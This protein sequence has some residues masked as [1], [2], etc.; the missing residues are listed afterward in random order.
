MCELVSVI[1]P[2]YNAENYIGEAIQ[3]VLSQTYDYWELIVVDDGSRDRTPEIVRHW[4]SLDPRIK[5]FA[6]PNGGP[7]KARNLG[8]QHARGNL[9]AFLDADDLWLPTRLEAQVGI[10]TVTGADLVF[11]DGYMFIGNDWSDETQSFG[12]IT[13]RFEGREMLPLLFESNRIPMLSVL[14]RRTV[15]QEACPFL[16]DRYCED[17][18]LWLRLAR[19]GVVF[20]GMADKLVRYRRHPAS[21]TAPHS[22]KSN[23]RSLSATNV[24]VLKDT[25]S[26][27]QRHRNA[28]GLPTAVVRKRF[29][30]LYR[31]LIAALLEENSIEEARRY[32]GEL[33]Q[34][35]PFSIK[36]L[37]QTLLV[38]LVP[39][40]YGRIRR[41][42]GWFLSKV[43]PR[44]KPS[45][46]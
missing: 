9:V 12:T 10:L 44:R 19:R 34:L 15:L 45:P 43:R 29:T 2:A 20:Y 40:H 14:M 31:T 37:F 25:V 6:Q 18:D 42:W 41:S 4:A 46:S 11:T 28:P 26:V 3:S 7:G 1:M 33:R 39:R 32:V 5:Y 23:L 24:R 35:E 30:E 22:T 17:Y 13:G 27:L 36:T 21:A 16:E 8:I 38:V